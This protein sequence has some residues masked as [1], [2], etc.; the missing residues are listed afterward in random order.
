MNTGFI[1]SLFI[2]G[3]G[4]TLL[5]FVLN[6][7]SNRDKWKTMWVSIGKRIT[8]FGR[9]KFGKDFWEKLENFLQDRIALM[10]QGLNEGL[11]YDNGEKK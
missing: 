10:W 8:D 7:I 5:I 11:D 3:A 1:A 4:A 6:R 2:N 9:G